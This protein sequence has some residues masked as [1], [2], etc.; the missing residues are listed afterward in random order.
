MVKIKLFN[1]D[2]TP[3]VEEVEQKVNSFLEQNDGEIIVREIHYDTMT[4]NPNNTVWK[5]W[6]VM[7]VYEEKK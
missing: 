2:S 7:V 1:V 3:S 5:S 6:T 4:P